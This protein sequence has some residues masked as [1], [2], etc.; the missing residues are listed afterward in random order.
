MLDAERKDAIVGDAYAR[1]FM[2][3]LGVDV[4]NRFR[5]HARAN[6]TNL[7][8]HRIID[9]WLRKELKDDPDTS[10]ILLGAGFDTRAYRFAGGNWF[11]VAEPAVISPTDPCL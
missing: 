6:T 2:S 9:D 4:V 1:F 11:E 10:V 3:D 5:R 8:R 7:T